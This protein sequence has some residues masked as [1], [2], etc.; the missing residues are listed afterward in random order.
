M[1]L[2][3]H[4]IDL[5]FPFI[6]GYEETSEFIELRINYKIVNPSNIWLDTFSRYMWL[7][8][9]PIQHKLTEK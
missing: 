9:L 3:A 2:K 5:F 1:F 4:V 7:V 8:A 6:S